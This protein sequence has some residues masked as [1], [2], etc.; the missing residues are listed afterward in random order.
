MT[1]WDEGVEYTEIADAISEYAN[2]DG[3]HQF[4]ALELIAD[5]YT[6]FGNLPMEEMPQIVER[7]LEQHGYLFWYGGRPSLGGLDTIVTVANWGHNKG[8]WGRNLLDRVGDALW[9]KFQDDGQSQDA[10]KEYGEWI[11]RVNEAQRSIIAFDMSSMDA[12][13]AYDQKRPDKKKQ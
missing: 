10:F 2:G 6:P 3:F 13:E 11:G 7:I 1:Q 8:D 12:E 5:N 9:Q 4:K